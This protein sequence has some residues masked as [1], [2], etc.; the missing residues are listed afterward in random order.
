MI[1]Y[2]IPSDFHVGRHAIKEK[3]KACKDKISKNKVLSTKNKT[4][5]LPG[6]NKPVRKKLKEIIIQFDDV[7]ELISLIKV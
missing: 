4:T 3:K 6:I 7:S 2:S 1:S 5:L